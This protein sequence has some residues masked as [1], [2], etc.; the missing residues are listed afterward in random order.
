MSKY[1]VTVVKQ[2]PLNKNIVQKK[3]KYFEIISGLVNAIMNW[4]KKQ[5]KFR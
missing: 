4:N 1:W 5:Y 2:N 3:L